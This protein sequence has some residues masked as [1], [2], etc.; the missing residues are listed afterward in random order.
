MAEFDSTYKPQPEGS[1]STLTREEYTDQEG[2]KVAVMVKTFKRHQASN[3]LEVNMHSLASQASE[4]VVKFYS[5][6]A[7]RGLLRLKMQYCEQDSL[8]T[9]MEKRNGVLWP[10]DELLALYRS[11]LR[12]ISEVHNMRIAH[13]C[14]DC[15]NWLMT[16]A[17]EVKLSD[18]GQ[19]KQVK[20]K[21]TTFGHTIRA[22]PQ[23]ASPFLQKAD[24]STAYNP[25]KEDIWSLGKVFFEMS[26]LK[27]YQHLLTFPI[28]KLTLTV[29]NGLQHYNSPELLS[30]ILGMLQPNPAERLAAGQCLEIVDAFHRTPSSPPASPPPELSSGCLSCSSVNVI[31]ELFDC[32]HPTCLECVKK[33]VFKHV[34][35]ACATCHKKVRVND[36]LG[37]SRVSIDTKDVLLGTMQK[38]CDDKRRHLPR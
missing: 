8:V 33:W 19:A 22:N 31:G 3:Y 2:R 11:M 13:R 12:T 18:F 17:G 35:I 7:D 27:I 37:N 1:E 26:V 10:L 36:L 4:G 25:F 38:A 16:R 32:G 24:D 14:I 30:L 28:E 29:R 6:V 9:V 5:H 34:S 20:S 23:Y 15:S 21:E